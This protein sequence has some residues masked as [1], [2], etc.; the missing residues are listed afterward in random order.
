MHSNRQPLSLTS[1]HKRKRTRMQRLKNRPYHHNNSTKHNLHLHTN[2]LQKTRHT[3]TPSRSN[4]QTSSTTPRTTTR[5]QHTNTTHHQSLSLQSHSLNAP[6]V[7]QNEH[8]HQRQHTKYP[9]YNL[10]INSI[11]RRN[12][13]QQYHSNKSSPIPNQCKNRRKSNPSQ[14]SS[15][16][17]NTQSKTL[18]TNT[19]DA[20]SPSPFTIRCPTPH[21]INLTSPLH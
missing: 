18:L 5:I 3:I 21:V 15:L 9:K 8:R 10:P 19:V 1:T 20:P 16:I 2:P 11:L 17:R 7:T 4:P 12:Q 14:L 6:S 13:L